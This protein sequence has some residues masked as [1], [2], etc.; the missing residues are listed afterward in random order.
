MSF[1]I[2]DGDVIRFHHGGKLF[3]VLF[4]DDTV[5]MNPR[6]WEE[7][8]GKMICWHREYRLGDQHDFRTPEE[9]LC[10]LAQQY[11]PWKTVARKI[12]NGVIPFK[13]EYSENPEDEEPFSLVV[14]YAYPCKGTYEICSA[15]T[16]SELF[17]EQNR[18]SIL[19]AFSISDLLKILQE[20]DELVLLPLWLYDHSGISMS[21]THTYPYNDRWDSGQVGWIYLTKSQF[22]R[23]AGYGEADWPKK[24]QEILQS[25]V[26]IYDQYLRG[27]VFGYQVFEF[28]RNGTDEWNETDESCWGFFGDDLMQN[29]I[30]DSITGLKEAL[31]SG[32][33]DC[34][35]DEAWMDGFEIHDG[36]DLYTWC[37]EPMEVQR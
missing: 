33:W 21:T 6:R 20:S 9:F 34:C 30:L 37:L 17:S 31:A 3:A 22:L 10:D 23:E 14:S 28:N 15:R 4:R 12:L 8:L 5:P 35:S 18:D 19:E 11:V 36:N 2:S 25:E 1:Y 32:Q 24:A 7:P 26:Q 13:V 16:V 27:E 29:G